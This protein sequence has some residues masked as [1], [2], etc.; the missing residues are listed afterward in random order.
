MLPKNRVVAPWL[1]TS[2]HSVDGLNRKKIKSDGTTAL[3]FLIAI[4]AA[5]LALTMT[6]HRSS[7]DMTA[8]VDR[9]SVMARQEVSA[10]QH[11]MNTELFILRE[12]KNSGAI[13]DL[14]HVMNGRGK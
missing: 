5:I 1:H 3:V 10:A 13:M 14:W 9:K 12:A 4:A 7:E 2:I 8:Q 6:G 11:A